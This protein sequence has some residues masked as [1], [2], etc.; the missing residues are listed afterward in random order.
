LR[1]YARRASISLGFSIA[2]LLAGS[3]A[4]SSESL[5]D[6][7]QPKAREAYLLMLNDQHDEAVAL[8]ERRKSIDPTF[9]LADFYLALAK[10]TEAYFEGDG[11]ARKQGLEMALASVKSLQKQSAEQGKRAEV[12]HRIGLAY[13]IAMAHTAR[14]RFSEGQPISAFRMAHSANEQA[15]RLLLVYPEHPSLQLVMG[16]YEYHSGNVP[17]DLSWLAKL[18]NLK[19]DSSKGLNLIKQAVT[20]S[21]E[22]GPEAARALINE[23]N[24][25]VPEVCAYAGLSESLLALAPSNAQLAIFNQGIYLHCGHAELALSANDRFQKQS[26][27]VRDEESRTLYEIRLRSLSQLGHT[28]KLLNMQS[29]EANVELALAEAYDMKADQRSINRDEAINLYTQLLTNEE[30]DLSTMKLVNQRLRRRVSVRKKI[31]LG[32]TL[33]LASPHC[34]G[35]DF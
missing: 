6:C 14:I 3:V 15:Q 30:I 19:G 13:V 9:L 21:V 25:Q 10:W 35:V 16:L 27:R 20:S 2:L 1:P 11:A 4:T 22:F 7:H 33:K 31:Q 34:T 23:V 8:L 12:D 28:G 24:W 26:P 17:D 32:R 18:F 29:E 5:Q